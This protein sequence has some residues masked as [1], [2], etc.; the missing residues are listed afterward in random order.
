M[1]ERPPSFPKPHSLHRPSLSPSRR[2]FLRPSLP[3]SLRPS[4]PASVPSSI[5]P[6]V[7][8]PLAPAVARLRRRTWTRV[9][10]ATARRHTAPPP[11]RVPTPTEPTG[12]GPAHASKCRRCIP[13]RDASL[14]DAAR[15]PGTDLLRRRRRRC[16][17]RR[18][19][20]EA[21][22]GREGADQ[23]PRVHRPQVS[24]RPRPARTARREH[25]VDNIPLI[26]SRRPRPARTFRRPRL[27]G[28]RECGSSQ[29]RVAIQGGAEGSRLRGAPCQAVCAAR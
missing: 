24:P 5:P 20:G 8:S 28:R 21:R 26:T 25:P 16:R 11:R 7:L 6:S 19:D 22:Q 15:A 2:P 27:F 23:Q 12:S 18:A 1:I 4:V 14:G 17:R 3:P 13:T 29:P 9:R 10:R